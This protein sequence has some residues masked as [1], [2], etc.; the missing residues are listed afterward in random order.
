MS[1]EEN[2]SGL[3]DYEV[4]LGLKSRMTGSLFQIK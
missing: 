3:D 2:E 4:S 1:D